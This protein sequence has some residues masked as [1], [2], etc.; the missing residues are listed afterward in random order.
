MVVKKVV[1]NITYNNNTLNF[2][3]APQSGP[4][5]APE[6]QP[7]APPP[8]FPREEREVRAPY[9]DRGTYRRVISTCK[10]GL[11]GDCGNCAS[12]YKEIAEFAPAACL[13][14]VRK[15]PAFLAAV[16]AYN[17]AYEARDLEGAREARDT[18][19]AL[20]PT[21]C[22]PCRKTQ[23]KLTG[24]VK[25]CYECWIELRQEACARHGGC[26]KEGCCERGPNAWQVLEADHLNPEDKIYALSDYC[27]WSCHGG[28]AAMRAEAAK[29]QWLCRF[30][31][32]LEPT[33]SQANRCG[34]PAAM[35]DGDYKGTEEEKAQYETKRKAKIRYP[36]Q[37]YVDAEKRR[38][39]CCLTC[40]RKVTPANVFAFQFDHRDET[41]KMKGKGT[42]AGK[43]GGVGGLVQNCAKRAALP[44]IKDVLDNEMTI[45]D[46]LCA[47]C[48]KR[49]TFEYEAEDE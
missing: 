21:N 42:L 17:A 26:M 32:F 11:F 36:K 7:E 41:T 16:E 28:P 27:W 18:I 4:A 47:N 6:A 45:C 33:G 29:C 14:N 20:R 22:K 2:H 30:C 23:K 34:D 49:K 12:K 25:A 15:R 38:R 10:G 31:H 40:E 37:E 9:K 24:Q 43:S 44:K 3:F 39:G 1:K 35:P 19:N 8:L 13:Q 5:P 48:H 46:L